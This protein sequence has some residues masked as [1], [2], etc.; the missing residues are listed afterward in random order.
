MPPYAQT[1]LRSSLFLMGLL[2]AACS[3]STIKVQAQPPAVTI[4]AP[5]DGTSVYENIELEFRAKAST[6]G[7][8]GVTDLVASWVA[9][10][11]SM[12]TNEPVNADGTTTCLYTFPQKGDAQV[13]VTVATP[14]GETAKATV[15]ITVVDNSAPTIDIVSPADAERFAVE[16]LIVFN[17]KVTDTESDPQ[18][19]VV[20]VNS[21][22]DGELELGG[23][24]TSSGDFSAGGYLTVGTHLITMRVEDDAGE[25]DQDT[26][27]LVIYEH[28]PP[29]VE[30]VGILPTPPYT[31]DDLLADPQGW[32]DP[33]G[34][35]EKY[36]YRW[37]KMDSSG[38]MVED[39]TEATGSF[40]AAKT[41]KHDLIQVEV[42][43]YNDYGEGDPRRSP[44]V[45][46]LNAPPEAPEVEITPSSPEPDD[47]L[48]CGIVTP[49]YDADG[50]PVTYSYSW[51]RNGNPT[52][53]T[54]NI[55]T[56]DLVEH[57]DTWDCFVTPNDG[58]DDGDVG[59]AST[60]AYDVTPPDA[61]VIDT[62]YGYRNETSLTLTGTCEAGCA[63]TYY[64]GNSSTTW[65]TSDVCEA[66]GTFE[67]TDTTHIVR[68][69]TTWCYA[70][71]VDSAGNASVYSNTVATEVCDPY[72]PYE[73][74]AT[75]GDSG[76]DPVDAFSTLS[77]AGTSTIVIEANVLND[78]LAGDWYVVSTSD[79]V[80]SDIAAGIN[81]YNFEVTMVDGSSDYNMVVY[82]DT[83]D[84]ADLE[85]PAAGGYTEYSDFV[86][87]VGDG[88][89]TG[90][91]IPS[92]TRSCSS[93]VPTRNNCEDM[94]T[95]YY[96]Y[97]SRKSSTVSSCQGYRLEIT[98]G[99]W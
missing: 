30:T 82:K 94:S 26:V 10:N 64:C 52:T 60:S 37:F 91:T 35:A 2:L 24:P 57:G 74:A 80:A 99:V 56:A 68:G 17:A 41:T 78:D 34:S 96:I 90:H 69:D 70:D 8:D 63:L 59:S 18:D 87:D 54:T 88:S 53:V 9:N 15:N 25:N 67:D 21:S 58:E 27:T 76:A 31:E 72:D 48:Y 62:P 73:D 77:D 47:N 46:I 95:D 5:A 75:Y 38:T 42:T 11:E 55:V 40:P 3:D 33:D 32:S 43:P 22:L 6:Y 45:E 66:D 39:T 93:G 85:C 23:S 14:T 1:S 86:Q 4:E 16:D 44:S 98:N 97:V 61:P 71:C 49:S 12:C 51:N 84:L 29:S 36:R 28:G 92:D 50:D 65:T 81:Y 7:G 89:G 83:Y 79:D 13:E 20:T 19:L